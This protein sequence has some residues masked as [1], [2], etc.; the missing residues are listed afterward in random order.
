MGTAT[1]STILGRTNNPGGK[2]G[3]RSGLVVFN[4]IHQYQDYKNIEVLEKFRKKV[5]NEI[6]LFH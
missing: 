4:E 2:D 5:N 6:E 3:M 1:K